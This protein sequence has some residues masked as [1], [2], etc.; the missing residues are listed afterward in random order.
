PRG[1]PRVDGDSG[2]DHDAERVGG[3]GG[4][5]AGARPTLPCLARRGRAGSARPRQSA[6][7]V[8]LSSGGK[9][10]GSVAVFPLARDRPQGAAHERRQ[11]GHVTHFTFWAKWLL[12][13]RTRLPNRWHRY[14][15]ELRFPRLDG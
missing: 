5:G 9:P 4:D 11:I 12:A 13:D 15:A 3:V 6:R 8:T 1:G 14:H 10:T 7:R 2:V